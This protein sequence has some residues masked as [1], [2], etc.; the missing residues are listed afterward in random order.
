MENKKQELKE[1]KDQLI[2]KTKKLGFNATI[3]EQKE[4]IQIGRKIEELEREL[5]KN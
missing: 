3:E 1:L 2:E 5:N 4:V